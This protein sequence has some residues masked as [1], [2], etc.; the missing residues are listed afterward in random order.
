MLNLNYS[1]RFAFAIALILPIAVI[2]VASTLPLDSFP[3]LVSLADLFSSR[4]SLS[5]VALEETA[6]K[7]QQLLQQTRSPASSTMSSIRR[8]APIVFPASSRHTAT[9]IFAHGLGDTGRGWADAVQLWQKKQRLN[10]VKFILPNAP[11]IPISMV[12]SPSPRHQFLAA[13]KLGY[14]LTML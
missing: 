3:S 12:S 14:I 6:R 11:V 13:T 7:Q 4:P 9:V 5:T 2:L 10:E 8:V 1:S